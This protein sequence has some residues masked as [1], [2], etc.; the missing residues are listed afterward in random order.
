M[1]QHCIG[2]ARRLS[3]LQFAL[4]GVRRDA[5][6]RTVDG[7]APGRRVGSS[8]TFTIARTRQSLRFAPGNFALVRPGVNRE[9]SAVAVSAVQLGEDLPSGNHKI[10]LRPL[11]PG[12][13]WARFWI[14]GRNRRP[15]TAES[16]IITDPTE[17]GEVEE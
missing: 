16:F 7:G 5:L 11:A 14:E 12:R 1:L 10:K 15:D 3:R 4:D 13:Y 2:L 9:L 6:A 17:H 8:S